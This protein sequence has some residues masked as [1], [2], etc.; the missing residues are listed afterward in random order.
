LFNRGVVR[1]EGKMDTRGALAD[2]EAL[3]KADPNYSERSRV[4][5]M[6]AQ[7]KKHANVEPREGHQP[8]M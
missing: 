7:A 3:L 4:E 2:W 5:Q 6:I 8:P 1:W